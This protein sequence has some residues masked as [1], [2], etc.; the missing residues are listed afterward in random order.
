[1]II[2]IKIY[3]TNYIYISIPTRPPLFLL[4][5]QHLFPKVQGNSA[6][7]P[8]SSSEAIWE[9]MA[10]PRR[11]I[12][13]PEPMASRGSLNGLENHRKMEVLLGKP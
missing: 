1:M 2:C 3:H 9:T 8:W 5:G 10:M 11:S 7:W 13:V 6:D 4:Q 12:S